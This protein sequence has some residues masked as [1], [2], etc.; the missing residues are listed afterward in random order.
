MIGGLGSE[1]VY[2]FKKSFFKLL[3]SML[4]QFSY[5]LT[6]SLPFALFIT[7]VN[8]TDFFYL[9]FYLLSANLF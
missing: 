3:T 2:V 4:K 8:A 9:L 1:S 5:L 6:I 7:G